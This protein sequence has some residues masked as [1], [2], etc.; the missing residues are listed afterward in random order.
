MRP[1]PRG[2]R[3][4]YFG[5]LFFL[6]ALVRSSPLLHDARRSSSG[7]SLVSLAPVS[8]CSHLLVQSEMGLSLLHS[9]GQDQERLSSIAILDKHG[10]LY[11]QSCAIVHIMARMDA[12]FPA[13][14]AVLQAVP[15]PLRDA[16]YGFV[17]RRR[18]I[19]GTESLSCRIPEQD[20]V[21]R[22]IL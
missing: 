9:F 11:T 13:A 10:H 6:E 18:H 12:P 20:E 17:S 5:R 19:F 8:S 21:D 16:L 1:L 22:F 4:S 14:A 3:S 7:F 2:S 15:R